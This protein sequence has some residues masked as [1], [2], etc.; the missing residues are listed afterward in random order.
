MLFMRSSGK[1]EADWLDN[2]HNVCI[3][4]ESACLYEGTLDSKAYLIDP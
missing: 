3:A 4:P 2:L 1:D